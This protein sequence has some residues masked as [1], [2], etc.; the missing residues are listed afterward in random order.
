MIRVLVVDDHPIV[1]AGIVG[2]LSLESDIE[3]IA[4]VENGQIALD[5]LAGLETDSQ[6]D[7]VLMDLRMPVLDG[8]A[9]TQQIRRLYPYTSVVVLT[10]YDSDNDILRAVEAGAEGYLL[11]DCPESELLDTVRDAALGNAALPQH[12][13]AAVMRSVRLPKLTEPT[14]RELEVLQCVAEGR[15]NSQIAAELFISEATVKTHLQ[16]LYTKLDVDSR[17]HCVTVARQHGWLK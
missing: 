12:A 9:T 16:R 8:V 5:A 17:T 2:L 13:T 6:C 15:T 10:T 4:S 1:R 11:K 14:R 7:V 3:V